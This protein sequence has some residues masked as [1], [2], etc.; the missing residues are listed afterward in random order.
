MGD[1]GGEEGEGVELFGFEGFLVGFAG[2]GEVA[3][4]HDGAE[5]AG[6]VVEFLDDGGEVEVEE[7]VFGVED[8]EVA[9]EGGGLIAGEGFPVESA[10]EF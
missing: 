3:D 4:E 9:G 8:F 2:F 7:A 6:L 10:D 1:A 5:V